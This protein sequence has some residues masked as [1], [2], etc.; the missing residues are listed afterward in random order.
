MP[1]NS[2]YFVFFLS[3]SIVQAPFKN[4]FQ[5]QALC[6][7]FLWLVIF[8]E[9][10]ENVLSKFQSFCFIFGSEFSFV[11][12]LSSNDF[13]Y[14]FPYLWWLL[15]CCCIGNFINFIFD[16]LSLLWCIC[17]MTVIS[18]RI[19][20]WWWLQLVLSLLFL[21]IVK[22]AV[23]FFFRYSPHFPR[24]LFSWSLAPFSKDNAKLL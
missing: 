11:S 6:L 4:L 12:C 23:Y 18:C 15:I 19:L 24:E 3:S 21:P 9:A 10:P 20:I 16:T 1:K 8:L 5:L 13:I 7:H 22:C 17:G 2:S 14:N